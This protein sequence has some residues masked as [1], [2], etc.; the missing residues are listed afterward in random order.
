MK[1]YATWKMWG[2]DGTPPFIFNIGAACRMGG[3]QHCYTSRKVEGSIPDA[4]IG[5][6]D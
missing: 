2:S 5:I 3:G 4:V 6:I 1:L